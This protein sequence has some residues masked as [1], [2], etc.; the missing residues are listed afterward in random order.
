M[1]TD[2]VFYVGYALRRVSKFRSDYVEL[3]NQFER[4]KEEA[5]A[6]VRH[7]VPAILTLNLTLHLLIF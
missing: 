3:R 2:R 1:H 7:V 5:A 6:A 4:Y